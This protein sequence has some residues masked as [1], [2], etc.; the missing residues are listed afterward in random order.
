MV[1]GQLRFGEDSM[2]RA[3]FTNIS[4]L[5]EGNFVRIAGVE[6]GKVKQI[7]ITPN[8]TVT[9]EFSTDDNVLL[10]EGTRAAI[11][12]DN[13]IG[14]RYMELLEGAGDVKPLTQGQIIPTSRTEP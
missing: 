4:G 14:G 9:V 11:R 1:F 2:Y 6:V 8:T 7:S 12:Y 5:E 13:V 10:T 3:E